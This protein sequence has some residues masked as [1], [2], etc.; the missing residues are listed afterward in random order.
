[1]ISQVC[2][3]LTIG[4]LCFEHCTVNPDEEEDVATALSGCLERLA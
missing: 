4:V 2:D 3:P 1:M